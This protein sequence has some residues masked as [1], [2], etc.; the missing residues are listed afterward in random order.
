MAK[1]GSKR[2]Q[3]WATM[4]FNDGMSAAAMARQLQRT[5]SAALLYF[6]VNHEVATLGKAHCM[7]V[8]VDMSNLMKEPEL[9]RI[10][11]TSLPEFSFG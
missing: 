4:V 8:Q 5:L 7:W 11:T 9:L 3:T 1:F 10:G 6:F 2:I